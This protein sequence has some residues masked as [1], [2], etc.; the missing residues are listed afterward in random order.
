[1]VLGHTPKKFKH[2]MKNMVSSL[3]IH[4]RIETT[5]AKV[6]SVLARPRG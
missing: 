2:M 1:M 6:L 3:I 4:E 5:H